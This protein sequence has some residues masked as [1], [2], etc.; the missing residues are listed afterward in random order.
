M[1]K[2]SYGRMALLCASTALAVGAVVGGAPAAGA[3]LPDGGAPAV[4][5][6]LPTCTAAQLDGE[7]E[8]QG[9]AAGNRYAALV[10]TNQGDP[11]TLLGHPTLAL[12]AVDGRDL[13]TA[14]VRRSPEEPS[15]VALPHAGRAVSDL[16]WIVGP[17]FTAGDD[18]TPEARPAAVTVTPP[19]TTA[20]FT[21]AWR[22]GA[23][24]GEPDGPAKI[25][26]SDFRMA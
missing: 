6:Q 5:A 3:A 24:C 11:C 21:I 13:L 20:G 14:S 8:Y 26:V 17:C 7:I 22:L 2:A 25:D 1:N 18:G 10:V 4:G 23:V 19:G 15:P 12:T 16:H 9:A